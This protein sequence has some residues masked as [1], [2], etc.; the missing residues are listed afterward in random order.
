MTEKK[1]TS[2]RNFLKTTSVLATGATMLGGLGVARSAHA[3][4][5]DQIKIALIGCG[6]RGSGA[7]RDRL[8]V[9]D[10]AKVVAIAD[11]FDWRTKNLAKGLLEDEKYKEK[12]DLPEDRIFAGIDAFKKAIDCLEPGDQVVIATPP[13]LRPFQYRAAVEKGCH[14]F[15]EKP[16]FT[17][18]F[19]YRHTMETNKM[20][21][22][23]NL[24]VC[25][26]LQRRYEP[27]YYNWIKK[28][29]DGEIG[30]LS[31]SRVYW[32]G[33]GIWCQ[34]RDPNESEMN[35][36]MKNWYHFVWL[37]GDNI[38]EQHVHNLDV[39]LWLHGKGDDMCHPVSAN[40][41]GGRTFKAGPEDLMRQAPSFTN[42]R[43]AWDEWYTKNK[44]AFNRHGQAWDH[45]C[46]EYT[47]PDGSHMFSQC[48][49]IANTW[50]PVTEFAHGTKG[51]GQ[52]GWLKDASGK[53]IW[54]NDEKAVK[55][56]YQW[57]HDC[58]VKAIRENTPMNN[59]YYAAQATM[60]AVFGREA[61]FCGQELKWDDFVAR[62]CELI[63]KECYSS[64]DQ[65]PPV[66]PDDDGFYESSVAVQGKYKA[67]KDA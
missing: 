35:Y 27:H 46:V 53:E 60:T 10:N 26:G 21:D 15:T 14:V 57:E 23:K 64:F 29:A 3:A 37:C 30:D 24:K 2:R 19:G 62:G 56:P 9:G 38:C 32:N 20:A 50:T 16:M 51:F 28:I 36:Q 41:Q 49:H 22:E 67:L 61:A 66:K 65:I 59:G 52:A 40:A 31:Y 39:G 17:D 34:K 25:V 42:D 11:A 58:H 7:I 45:F 55:G 8:Q 18:A 1:Q 33:G 48:R 13:G 12:V 5:S 4:G 6:G 44:N 54:K 47:F 63:P 43:P